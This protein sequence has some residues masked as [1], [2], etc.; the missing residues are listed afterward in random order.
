MKTDPTDLE[1]KLEQSH[2]DGNAMALYKT[3]LRKKEAL[4]N[5]LSIRRHVI[6]MR[7]HEKLGSVKVGLVL[8]PYP[9]LK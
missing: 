9:W 4:E 5:P 1:K 7:L 8:S 6:S 2:H 3:Y